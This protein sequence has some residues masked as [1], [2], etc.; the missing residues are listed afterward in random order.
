MKESFIF[1]KTNKVDKPLQDLPRKGKANQKYYEE[2]LL[3]IRLSEC[4]E[5]KR[6]KALSVGSCGLVI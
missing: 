1:D 3:Q 2:I 4:Y 5:H 6:G